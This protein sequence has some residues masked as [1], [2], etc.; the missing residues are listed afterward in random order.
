MGLPNSVFQSALMLCSC[1]LE[2]IRQKRGI[3]VDTPFKR[4]LCRHGDKNKKF[5]TEN[6]F[7]GLEMIAIRAVKNYRSLGSDQLLLVKLPHFQHFP[8]FLIIDLAFGLLYFPAA[9]VVHGQFH[10][11]LW[12]LEQAIQMFNFA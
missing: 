12:S 10:H 7:V 8:P 9:R 2:I 11:H 5:G 3:A 1:H 4:H 6:C